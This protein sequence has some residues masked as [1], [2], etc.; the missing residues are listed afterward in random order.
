M[1]K[2]LVT[3]LIIIPIYT[4]S[5]NLYSSDTI[6]TYSS[7]IST[8]FDIRRNAVYTEDLIMYSYERILPISAKFG[9]ILK[10]GIFIWD[11]FMP[12]AEIAAITGRTKHFFE[13]GPGAI[14]DVFYGGGFLPFVQV[15]D[16]RLLK[17]F[18]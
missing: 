14:M 1:K 12:V 8:M 9:L 13:A 4:F 15:T 6:L 7:E 17:D 2:L 11:P 16:I 10:G 18:Y 5:F 3:L